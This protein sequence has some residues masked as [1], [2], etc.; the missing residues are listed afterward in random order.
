MITKEENKTSGFII[1]MSNG[2]RYLIP[3]EWMIENYIKEELEYMK[4]DDFKE[5]LLD[6]GEIQ[7]SLEQ[8]REGSK[9]NFEREMRSG[10]IEE[11]FANLSWGDVSKVAISI[12]PENINPAEMW[13][14]AKI[15][16]IK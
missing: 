11:L 5:Y 2:T 3:T 15:I 9:R 10:D 7:P 14:S 6:Q 8:I 13:E 4:S 1:T 12:P 16:F